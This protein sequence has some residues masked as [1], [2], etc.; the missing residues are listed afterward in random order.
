MEAKFGILTI[1][2]AMTIFAME[3]KRFFIEHPTDAT[4]RVKPAQLDPRELPQADPQ[5]RP[6]TLCGPYLTKMFNRAFIDGL[7]NP[8]LRPSAGEWEEA[9][10]KTCD[11]L[12]PCSCEHGWYVFDNKTKPVCPFCGN[13]MSVNFRFSISTMPLPMASTFQ[14]TTA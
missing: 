8:G 13:P 1:F 3:K 7:H 9:L 5:Q 10:V 14:R 11:L 12:Q 4:N 2:S 6:Y